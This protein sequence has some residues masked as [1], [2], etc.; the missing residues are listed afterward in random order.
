VANWGD[1][2]AAKKHD[3]DISQIKHSIERGVIAYTSKK[4]DRMN[5]ERGRE[6]YN[7]TK[8]SNGSRTIGVHTEIDDRPSVMR[9]ATYTVN[10][11]WMPED[12]FL[13]LTVGD[14][15]MGTGWFKFF[16]GYAECESYT[17]MEGRISQR[18]DLKH[19]PLKSFQNH[20]IACDSWHFSHYD[21]SKGPGM[22]R[23]E[24]ILLCSPDHRGAT[25]PMIYPLG[26]NLVYVGDE[27]ITVGAG[28]FVSHHFQVPTNNELPE[29]HPPYEVYTSTDGDYTFLKGGVAGYMQTHYELM[30]LEKIIK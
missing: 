4:A 27:K 11:D 6:L 16:Q 5:H 9:D 22:Q 13:R 15:F 23:I 30:E 24:E 14:E 25:G 18:F 17:R 26:L 2:M 7:I 21:L 19:G 3:N 28:T 10:E 12:C 20:A 1:R 29:E 8:Y